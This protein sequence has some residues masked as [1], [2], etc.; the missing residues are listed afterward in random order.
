MVQ[1]PASASSRGK[2]KGYRDRLCT[3]PLWLS[4][5]Y[6]VSQL[7]GQSLHWVSWGHLFDNMMLK[8][9]ELWRALWHLT[10]MDRI[11]S[12]SCWVLVLVDPAFPHYAALLPF[13]NS[14]MYPVPILHWKYMMFFIIIILEELLLRD[15][16]ESQ[17]RLW[18]PDSLRTER[19][20]GHLYLDW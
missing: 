5:I 7:A 6:E 17:R 3:F 12:H 19:L 20:W 9:L 8:N 18:N 4:K 2:K 1:V 11:W 15:W 10:W 13:V 14:S 16:F